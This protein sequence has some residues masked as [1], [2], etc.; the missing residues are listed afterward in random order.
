LHHIRLPI[1]FSHLIPPPTDTSPGRT[2]STPMFSNFV[3]ERKH[4]IFVYLR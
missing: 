1:T 4:D 2:C 3:K